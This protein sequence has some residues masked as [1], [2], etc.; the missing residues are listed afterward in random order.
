M[1]V[2]LIIQVL[3]A[4]LICYSQAFAESGNHADHAGMGKEQSTSPEQLEGIKTVKK[5]VENGIEITLTSQS[6]E[7]TAEVQ[8]NA[9]G[10]YAAKDCPGLKGNDEVKVENIENGVKV[11]VTAKSRAG[12]KKLQ[13]SLKKG[14]SCCGEGGHE[15]N[16]AGKGSKITARYVCPMGDFPGSD[17]PGKC[18]KCGMNL[19]ENK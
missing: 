10:Y 15:K 5:A 6:P 9:A 11:T 8:K 3:A 1:K 14:K 16:S 13:S 18:P 19:V 2:K 7:G 12:V 4:L 17:K